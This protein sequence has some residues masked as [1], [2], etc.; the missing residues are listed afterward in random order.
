MSPPVGHKFVPQSF[1][2]DPRGSTGWCCIGCR[3]AARRQRTR[4][5]RRS[6]RRRKP[7]KRGRPGR[8]LRHSAAAH[9]ARPGSSRCTFANYSQV[10]ERCRRCRSP[11]G[12]AGRAHRSGRPAPRGRKRR[13]SFRGSR[14]HHWRHSSLADN[15]CCRSF[16][17]RRSCPW[18][19]CIGPTSRMSRPRRPARKRWALCPKD[20]HP[21]SCNIRHSSRGRRWKTPS[22]R[23]SQVLAP[24]GRPPKVTA[25]SSSLSIDNPTAWLPRQPARG[26]APLDRVRDS[27]CS[28]PEAEQALNCGLEGL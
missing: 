18:S 20:K 14:S 16:P 17:N 7:G 23:H 4:R 3:S 13:G 28:I 27:H 2:I 25:S 8:R 9:T 22:Y 5:R 1:R 26:V 19:R 6:C 21:E 12:I 10:A 24:S 11:E 15:S